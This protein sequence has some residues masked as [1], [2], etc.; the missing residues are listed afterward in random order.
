MRDGL[1]TVNASPS[2]GLV[3]QELEVEILDERGLANR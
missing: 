1:V 3:M 2:R